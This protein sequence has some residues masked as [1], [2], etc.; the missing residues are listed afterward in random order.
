MISSAG[1]IRAVLSVT[2]EVAVFSRA[3]SDEVFYI[4]P[5]PTQTSGWNVEPTGMSAPSTMR[6]TRATRRRSGISTL[7]ILGNE[8]T[9][10]RNKK[11]SLY[12]AYNGPRLPLLSQAWTEGATWLIVWSAGS[13]DL[14]T[15]IQATNATGWSWNVAGA[16]FQAG[17]QILLWDDD[18]S[19]SL[20]TLALASS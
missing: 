15:R 1:E 10:F 16:S 7:T 5:D 8:G 6:A 14:P 4:F 11:T 3:D 17:T 13:I 18:A 2:G 9:A 12:I 19:N 20:F